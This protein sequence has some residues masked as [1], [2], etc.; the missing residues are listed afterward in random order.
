MLSSSFRRAKESVDIIHAM[1]GCTQPLQIDEALNE[2][3]LGEYN[4]KG[5]EYMHEIR[6]NDAKDDGTNERQGVE[7][8]ISCLSK[9]SELVKRM[10]ETYIN[11]D[12]ILVS[13]GDPLRILLAG[14]AKDP[15]IDPRKYASIKR[16]EH[17]EIRG[18]TDSIV[19]G[20]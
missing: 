18:L 19:L 9:M 5:S 17:G 12:I 14:Y 6:E 10:E 1:L 8:V 16:F 13:H 20:N 7:H 2:R 4:L 3:D 15:K 11:K